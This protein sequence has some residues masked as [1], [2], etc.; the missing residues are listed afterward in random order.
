MTNTTAT[1]VPV[2]RLIKAVHD[3]GISND[4]ALAIVES[5]KSPVTKHSGEGET[6]SADAFR[7]AL[8][9]AATAGDTNTTARATLYRATVDRYNVAIGNLR[10]AVGTLDG[11]AVLRE[12]SKRDVAN[13]VWLEATGALHA[14]KA[15]ERTPGETSLGQYLSK[16]GTVATSSEYGMEVVLSGPDSVEAAYDALGA[17]NRNAKQAKEDRAFTV[18][19]GTETPETRAAFDLVTSIMFGTDDGKAHRAAFIRSITPATK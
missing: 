9:A 6:F 17:A 12:S 5:V 4:E 2:S 18:W 15:D 7:A 8:A 13:L 10:D 11:V 1:K 16:L 14:P 3:A 19:I